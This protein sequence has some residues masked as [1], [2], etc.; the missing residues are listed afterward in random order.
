MNKVFPILVLLIQLLDFRQSSSQDTGAAEYLFG[1][2]DGFPHSFINTIYQDSIGF[3]WIGSDDGLSKYDGYGFTSFRHIPFDTSSVSDNCIR[4]ICEDINGDL[5]IGTNRG[6]N[7]LDRK[8]GSFTNY[9]PHQGDNNCLSEAP[10]YGLCTDTMGSIWVKTGNYLHKL[11]P[12]NGMWSHYPYRPGRDSDMPREII[13]LPII[14]DRNGNLWHGSPDGLY[15]FNT[16]NGTSSFFA[17]HVIN[18]LCLDRKGMLWIGTSNGLYCSYPGNGSKDPFYNSASQFF[19]QVDCSVQCDHYG[20]IF[21]T[22][23]QGLFKYDPYRKDFRLLS[24]IEPVKERFGITAINAIYSDR[25]EIF[26]L[27]TS[28][29]L[30]RVSKN[31]YC[32]GLISRSQEGMY[33]L[34]SDNISAILADKNH[35]WLG[36]A[37]KGLARIEKETGM[38]TVFDVHCNDD[39]HIPGNYLYELTRDR[40]GT[41]W[42]GTS[43]G[44][45]FYNEGEELFEDICELFPEIPGDF[46]RGIGVY[47]ILQDASE[48]YWMATARGLFRYNPELQTFSVIDNINIGKDTVTVSNI[49]TMLEDSEGMI[50]FGTD[51]GLIRYDHRQ[52]AFETCHPVQTNTENLSPGMIYCLCQDSREDI[53]IGTSA[54]LMH[55]NREKNSFTTYTQR[56]GLASNHIYSIAEDQNANLWLSSD[57]GLTRYDPVNNKSCIYGIGNGSQNYLFNPG[58]FSVDPYG[59]FYFGGISGVYVFHPDSVT[60]NPYIP[61]VAFTSF[62]LNGKNGKL[63]MPLEKA[64]KI[65]VPR[66]KQLFS[67]YFSALEYTMPEKNRYMYQ[68]VKTGEEGD[69][70]DIGNQHFVTFF[71]LS[72]GSYKFTVRGSNNDQVWNESGS[73][74]EVRVLTPRWKSPEAYILYGIVALLLVYVVVQYRT[75]NLRQSNRILKEKEMNAREVARQREE[76]MIKNKNITDSIN[77]ARRIQFALLPTVEQFSSIL[78]ESFILYK[79]KDIVSGDFYWIN[80]NPEK[81]YVAAIDCTG[82]GVPGAF[83]SIIGFELFRKITEGH[84]EPNPARILDSLNDNY[85]D[86]FSDGEHVYLK[87]GMDVAMCVFDKK[88]KSL[89]FSGA[90]NPLYLI[91]D[92]TII[93]IKADRSS[94]GAEIIQVPN[95][96]RKFKS[97]NLV[98]Q[99]ND[100]MYLFSDG[101]ADQFGGPEGKK[102]KYRRFRHLLLTIHQLPLQRQRSI[103]EASFEEWKREMD[104]V[105]DILV[106]GIRPVFGNKQS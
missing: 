67:I 100:I 94:I 39:R 25:S 57:R 33:D 1:V 32:F 36:T 87:D 41:L 35:L 85:V 69:W 98:L 104:Q 79:P 40:S 82:H 31:M 49:F 43:G 92:E 93:E 91:R 106:I 97:H 9:L 55:L 38:M 53:W 73:T 19:L 14:S 103:L 8:T 71:N 26:W 61:N 89:E 5:W 56:D 68:M 80:E 37:G 96:R 90:Y 11:D 88:E 47:S 63:I 4:A 42:I 101:Y 50:W 51:K 17:R 84:G 45:S 7:R 21:N 48:N 10:V 46:F 105:D 16:S 76:L 34:P 52:D 102:F 12:L 70:I 75:R 83:M 99:E 62:E 59:T 66:G 64:F 30:L 54:G 28:R 18:S 3:L 60:V 13:R 24:P 77:Y 6:L 72:P 27:A 2:G 23:P 58:A 15:F 65:I 74:M 86:I 22:T 78:P 29:G 20:N 44:I 81:I 95:E